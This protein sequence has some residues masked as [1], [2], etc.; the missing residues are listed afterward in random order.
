MPTPFSA[1]VSWSNDAVSAKSQYAYS[2]SPQ[3]PWEGSFENRVDAEEFGRETA[4]HFAMVWTAEIEILSVGDLVRGHLFWWLTHERDAD[5]DLHDELDWDGLSDKAGDLESKVA[6][7]IDDWAEEHKCQRSIRQYINPE[8]GT[9]NIDVHSMWITKKGGDFKYKSDGP[10]QNEGH[11]LALMGRIERFRTRKKREDLEG[12]SLD[13]RVDKMTRAML[14]WDAAFPVA[15]LRNYERRVREIKS[16]LRSPWPALGTF[17]RDAQGKRI[18]GA[19]PF[20][21]QP[22]GL[23]DEEQANRT[24]LSDLQRELRWL[25]RRLREIYPARYWLRAQRQNAAASET[26]PSTEATSR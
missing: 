25:K 9:Y 4:E 6:T 16:V 22:A 14:E 21:P 20:K 11:Y 2:Y 19:D 1:S 8:R 13:V 26:P 23:S 3:G 7:L 12:V 5:P 24:R 15:G 10:V 17:S 18:Y